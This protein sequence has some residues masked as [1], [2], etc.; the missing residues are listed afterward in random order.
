E[1][2]LIARDLGIYEFGDQIVRPAIEQIRIAD[3]RFV[4]GLRLIPIGLNHMIERF[5]HF[6]DFQR[7]DARSE[8]FVSI[9]CPKTVAA[10]YLERVGAWRL[11]KLV[12]ITTCPV[13][14]RDR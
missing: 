2:L 14:R 1:L 6:I 7:Y 11:R 8:A 3:D 12:A 4:P 10:T 5:T 9:D 13:L